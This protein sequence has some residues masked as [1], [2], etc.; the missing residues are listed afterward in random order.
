[1]SHDSA[2]IDEII[3]ADPSLD[4]ETVKA[5]F[6]ATLNSDVKVLTLQVKNPDPD[7]AVRIMNAAIPGIS[8]FAESLP[9]I[10]SVRVI[11]AGTDAA[12]I[13]PDIRLLR[14]IVLGAL[15]GIL[16]SVLIVSY[17]IISDDRIYLPE[18]IEK[19]YL[20][21]AAGTLSYA[22]IGEVLPDLAGDDGFILA[23]A[24]SALVREGSWYFDYDAIVIFSDD[25]E[26]SSHASGPVAFR[27]PYDAVAEHLK[28]RYLSVAPEGDVQFYITPTDAVGEADIE[29]I[30]MV[31]V[32]DGEQTLYL[33]ANG[34]AH[35][36]RL[37]SVE[38]SGAFYETAQLWSCSVMEKCAVQVSTWIPDGMP[39]LKL[40]YRTADGLQNLYLTQSGEDGSLILMDDSIEAIG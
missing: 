12:P 10:V 30:D 27:I 16:F 19:R 28:P 6:L 13:P 39:N 35:D 37:T 1:M 34:K 26:I 18:T 14:S 17:S 25:Y 11:G 33:I 29:I 36:V 22:N 8:A 5:S 15:I 20:I 4:S 38:Y 40:S 3:A 7:M 31:R 2:V 24:L 21:P 9:E 32:G 23:S